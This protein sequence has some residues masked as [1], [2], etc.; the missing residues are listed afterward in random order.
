MKVL[1]PLKTITIGG[2]WGIINA[3]ASA[4]GGRSTVS[5]KKR[6]SLWSVNS[7]NVKHIK[8]VCGQLRSVE[9]QGEARLPA[10]RP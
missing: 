2:E 1:H 6:L 3:H 10:K 7:Y 4:E 5:D 8:I 9:G